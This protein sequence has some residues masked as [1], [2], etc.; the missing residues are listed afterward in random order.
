MRDVQGRPLV[1][2]SGN[3][4]DEPIAYEEADAIDRLRGIADLFLTHNRPIHLRCDDSVTR[5]IAGKELPVRRSRGYA[6]QPVRL[7][8]ECI[9]PTLAVGGQLKVAFALGHGQNAI[10]SHH[11]GDLDHFAAYTAFER[12]IAHFERLFRI[13]PQRIAHDLHPDYM[14]T[15]YAQKRAETSDV[16]LVAVQHHHAHMVSCMAEHG[17]TEPVVGVTFDGTGYG[18]DGTVW[19]GEFLVGDYQ[20]FRRAGHLRDVG[21]P[22]GEQAI[23]EPWRMAVSHLL[24]A[25]CDV[26]ALESLVP[27]KAIQ[28]VRAIIQRRIN[29]PMTSSIGRLFDAVSKCGPPS[30]TPR[31]FGILAWSLRRACAKTI[32][33]LPRPPPRRWPSRR[34]RPATQPRRPRRAP[35]RPHA[36]AAKRRVVGDP[37]SRPGTRSCSAVPA[38]ETYSELSRDLPLSP[39]AAQSAD[40]AGQRAQGHGGR[41]GAGG[42]HHA[43]FGIKGLSEDGRH[44][45]LGGHPLRSRP[46][47]PH[48][49]CRTIRP[50][51]S[52]YPSSRF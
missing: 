33:L 40:E 36:R 31:R 22:G 26:T 41:G 17:L 16:E 39:P 27:A 48:P 19:G 10:L 38:S 37:R 29:T 43:P 46:R 24:D 7:P 2:T 51:I 1:M 5:V 3:R 15:R 28:T 18:T 30:G 34:P 8:V 49:F 21:M 42:W 50:V 47:T 45:W 4:C 44:P 14:S 35:S 11:M 25:E 6:P 23:R 52:P 20:S 9:R 12:N 32:T 13:R